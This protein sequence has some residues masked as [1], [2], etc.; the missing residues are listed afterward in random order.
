MPAERPVVAEVAADAP[1]QQRIG[2]HQQTGRAGQILLVD[3]LQVVEGQALRRGDHHI[4]HLRGDDVE[5]RFG[6]ISGLVDGHHLGA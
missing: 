2:Q 3:E 4:A 1:D 6:Q 5:L